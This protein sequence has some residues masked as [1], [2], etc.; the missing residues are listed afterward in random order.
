[1]SFKPFDKVTLEI[2]G[3]DE[4]I[5]TCGGVIIKTYQLDGEDMCVVSLLGSGDTLAVKQSEVTKLT[6]AVS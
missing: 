6:N 5:Y 1:M 2:T 4:I 3:T